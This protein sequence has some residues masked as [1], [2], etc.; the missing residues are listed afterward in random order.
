MARKVSCNLK[1]YASATAH[2]QT[3]MSHAKIAHSRVR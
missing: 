2:T 1:V 3:V